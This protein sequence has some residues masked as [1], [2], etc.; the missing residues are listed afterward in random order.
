[1]RAMDYRGGKNDR[2]EAA[3]EESR[4]EQDWVW[5]WLGMLASGLRGDQKG[6]G[7]LGGWRLP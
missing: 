5:P 1:M 6:Y 2:V 4:T 7:L 3:A